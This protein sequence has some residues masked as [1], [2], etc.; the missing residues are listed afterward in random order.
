MEAGQV[1]TGI[2]EDQKP[3]GLFVRLPQLGMGSGDCSHW[4]SCS[5]SDRGDVKRKLPPGTEIEWRSS[6]K[7]ETK[8]GSPRNPPRTEPGDENS[9]PREGRLPGNPGEIFKL[10]K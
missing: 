3:Y 9:S 5:E 6:R 1:L 10:K 8:F 7:K 4:R 2:V